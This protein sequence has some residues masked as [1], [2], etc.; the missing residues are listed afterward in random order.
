[1]TP[2]EI[3]LEQMASCRNRKN[4]FV[5]LSDALAGLN[6]RQA[7][8]HDKKAEHSVWQLVNHLIFWNERW[9]LRLRGEVP[10]EM[11]IDN[12]ET[13]SNEEPS[14][15]LWEQDKSKLDKILADCEYRLK[16][17]TDE[18]LDREAY[19]GYGS[20]WYEMFTQ[21]TVHNAYHIG[22][23]VLVRKIQGTW[24]PEQGVK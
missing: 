9:L 8:S 6:Y 12:S 4:W 3:I 20:T 22:Q 19:A 24:N 23:I 10:P 1:M 21:F 17:M 13:F 5:P 2:K 16:E 7:S 15:K 11:E 14:E 18:V